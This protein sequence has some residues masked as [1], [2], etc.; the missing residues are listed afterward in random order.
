MKSVTSPMPLPSRADIFLAGGISNCPDWQAEVEEILKETSGVLINP[1]RTTVF[2]EEDAAEQI[3]W[4]YEALR[5]VDTVLFWFPMETL[6]PITL[7]ELGVFTQR[8][9]VQLIVGTHPEYAR[10]FDVIKQLQLARPEVEVT[11]NI[12]DLVAAYLKTSIAD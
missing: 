8:T 3:E 9:D 10:R 7:L 6:C 12:D 5:K 2:V 11:D 1:R 4:E